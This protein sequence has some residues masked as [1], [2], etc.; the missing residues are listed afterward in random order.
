MCPRE[1]LVGPFDEEL[2]ATQKEVECPAGDEL[3]RGRSVDP[4]S[5]S[6]E[7]SR[8][9]TTGPS[10]ASDPWLSGARCPSRSGSTCQLGIRPHRRGPYDEEGRAV[11]QERRIRP[12]LP[13]EG[14]RRR[15]QLPL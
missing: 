11:G 7:R 6:V 1:S 9:L 12:G 14:L 15:R 2:S 5:A 13:N 3:V 4:N 8:R 10:A